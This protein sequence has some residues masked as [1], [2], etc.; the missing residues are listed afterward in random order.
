M[1]PRT[2][3]IEPGSLYLF[4]LIAGD[5]R[6]GRIH[7]DE[8][9]VRVRHHHGLAAMTENERRQPGLVFAFLATRN[10]QGNPYRHQFVVQHHQGAE[11]LEIEER[12]ILTPPLLL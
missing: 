1:A 10:I 9:A 6:E 7:T 11:N 2:Q 4:S 5:A 8:P 12:A 3:N